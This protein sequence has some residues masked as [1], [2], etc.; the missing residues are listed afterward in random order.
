MALSIVSSGSTAKSIG[1]DLWMDRVLARAREI[2]PR[3]QAGDVHALRVALRRSR[4]MA[5]ALR[6]V[7]PAPEWRKIKRGSRN[8]FH[9]LGDLRDTQVVRAWVRNLAPARDPVRMH[10]LRLFSRQEKKQRKAAAKALQDF[11]R[12]TWRKWKRRLE[13]K[14][15]FF[16]LESVVFQR[17]ALARL[18]E[19]FNLYQQARRSRSSLAWHRTRI[20]IK[21]FRY[22]VEN[23]LPQ[24]YAMWEQDIKHFQDLLGELHDLDVLRIIARRETKKFDPAAV[25]RFLAR[26]EQDR[27]AR[28]KE[29]LQK[30]AA[31]DSPWIAWR[32]GFRT[33]HALSAAP[34]A[35][36]QR[37]T[38]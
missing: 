34:A 17:I 27:A 30:S 11:D 1:L 33:V 26:I 13:P 21:R 25:A 35:T 36:A 10:L 12:K 20:G 28:L 9:A 16:P 2:E 6:E 5:E 18:G 24:R 3:W 37:R 32:E 15:R 19:A 22:V 23:F 4:T 38:A 31:S 7:S 29:F 8:L 14:A